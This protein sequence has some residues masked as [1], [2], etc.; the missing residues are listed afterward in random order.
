MLSMDPRI[1]EDDGIFREDDGI[2]REDDGI[3][4]RP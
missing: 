2:F 1:R 4:A 3:R